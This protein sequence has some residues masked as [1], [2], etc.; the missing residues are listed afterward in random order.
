METPTKSAT[1]MPEYVARVE[2]LA[3]ILSFF[4]SLV[5]LTF[6]L[7]A[8]SRAAAP[9]IWSEMTANTATALILALAGL[10][11]SSG[12]PSP[13]KLL[14][15]KA[16]AWIVLAVATLSLG[17]YVAGTSVGIDEWLPHGMMGHYPGR[18]S[19]QTSLCLAFIGASLLLLRRQKGPLSWL[20]D[21]LAVTLAVLALILLG[22][23]LYGA[24]VIVGVDGNTRTAP[25]TLFCICCLS[26]V[27][28]ARRARYGGVL[29]ILAGAGLGSRIARTTLPFV[30]LLPFVLFYSVAS[31][32]SLKILAEHYVYAFA[33]AGVALF[34][35]TVVFWM[36]GRINRLEHA[37]R[38]LSLTDDLTGLNNRRGFYILAEQ[39]LRESSRIGSGTT[40]FY[41]DLDG[42][43][44]IND[45]VGHEAGSVM[46]RSFAS[47]LSQNFRETDVIGRLG[48][49][50][51]VVVTSQNFG[52]ATEILARLERSLS[53]DDTPAGSA[54]RLSYS[55]GYSE[56]NPPRKPSLEELIGKADA[57]M[58]QQKLTKRRR[59]EA[60]ILASPHEVSV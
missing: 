8:P 50:E 21:M 58:Y 48:G 26:F 35:T 55:V 27:V 59:S 57:M 4:V 3:L 33:T 47:A 42:L 38:E 1:H 28:C 46:I 54:C 30:I 36:A 14:M 32:I 53:R 29:V 11:L 24:L 9:P 19:P 22:G 45:T 52:E 7:F 40:V 25:Q 39:V 12:Q 41:F 51:F 49:D 13:K 16:V 2:G 10:A 34:T 15:S 31:L 43:K 60:A 23:Y 6:W 20:A 56:L 17:E 5:I 44:A 18:P 37:L